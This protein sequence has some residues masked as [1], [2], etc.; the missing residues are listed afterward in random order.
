MNG[1]HEISLL[2]WNILHGGGPERTPRIGL[3][4]VARR[5]DVVV[6]CEFRP[7]RG[8]QLR[9][10]L[11]DAGLVHQ[12]ASPV[13]PTKNGMLLASR[14]ETGQVAFP[15]LAEFPG[16][17]L[18]AS[19]AGVLVVGVHVP[20]D[21][22]IAK[23]AAYFRQLTAWA[24]QNREKACVIA[25]DF[26][27]SRRGPDT[28]GP[29]FRLEAQL[30]LLETYGFVDAWRAKNPGKRE[31]SWVSSVGEGRLDGAYVS[32]PLADALVEATY[33]HAPREEG[34][35]DHSML[36]VRLKVMSGA[37]HIA[38]LKGLFG[39]GETGA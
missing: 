9:A 1:S 33:E 12:L 13:A 7:G 22:V 17:V 24:K 15:G 16:R 4:I 37:T 20:D 30:G 28:D 8:G 25:G 35:S 14:L 21:G 18:A 3:E 10:Q 23:K 6:L 34:L 31:D 32:A 29:A 5:P 11:A 38:G 36:I 2:A 19:I 26:N 27:T 39:R